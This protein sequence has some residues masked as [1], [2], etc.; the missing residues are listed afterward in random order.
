MVNKSAEA[1]LRATKILF[2][3]MKEVEQ[4]VGAVGT[5]RTGQTDAGGPGGRRAVHRAVLGGKLALRPFPI[6]PSTA[7]PMP[8]SPPPRR[9]NEPENPAKMIAQTTPEDHH[10]HEDS[11]KLKPV[12]SIHNPDSRYR[13]SRRTRHRRS[14]T[15]PV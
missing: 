11:E 14:R 2:D 4:K 10:P 3:M 15:K 12:T 13:L 6:R 9:R 7:L 1:D 8:R 5:R